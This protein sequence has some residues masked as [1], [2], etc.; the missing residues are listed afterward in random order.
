[1]IG[2]DLEWAV[3]TI[4]FEP[5]APE[6]RRIFES[7][8]SYHKI[9]IGETAITFINNTVYPCL[10][11]EGWAVGL[12]LDTFFVTSMHGDIDACKRDLTVL[13]LISPDEANP[14]FCSVGA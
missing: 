3:R 10:H 8:G 9:T 6:G 4:L 13:R 12:K 14:V 1:M 5:L 2:K 11:G 7:V